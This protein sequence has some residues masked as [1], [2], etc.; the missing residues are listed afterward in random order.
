MSEDK[1]P[2]IQLQENDEVGNFRSWIL[3]ITIGE[4]TAFVWDHPLKD[5]ESHYE[6][7]ILN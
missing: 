4:L 3:L 5:L 2:E 7:C 6:N 1:E